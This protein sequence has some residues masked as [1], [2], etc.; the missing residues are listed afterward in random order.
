ME[1]RDRQDRLQSEIQPL[2]DEKLKLEIMLREISW[3]DHDKVAH[4]ES[5]HEKEL[6]NLRKANDILKVSVRST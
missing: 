6:S 4:L 1:L 3:E 5:E 2:R